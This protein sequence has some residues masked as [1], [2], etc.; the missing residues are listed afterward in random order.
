MSSKRWS[1][2]HPNTRSRL[3]GYRFH[4]LAFFVPR[5]VTGVQKLP[6]RLTRVTRVRCG[7]RLSAGAGNQARRA[8]GRYAVPGLGSAAGAC[9]AAPQARHRRRT[10]PA[11]RPD[12]GGGAE[13][14]SGSGRDREARAADAGSDEVTIAD[15]TR[16]SPQPPRPRRPGRL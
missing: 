2:R 8:W 10:G 7:S 12:I 13:R 6:C 9:P 15:E 3:T 11:V 1:T 14:R 16:P 5:P 4:N